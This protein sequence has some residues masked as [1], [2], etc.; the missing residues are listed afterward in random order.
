MMKLLTSKWLSPPIGAVVYI[1]ATILLWKTPTVPHMAK[2]AVSAEEGKPSW[3]F[4]NPEAEQMMDELKLQK[5]A[6]DKREQQVA[7]A[8]KRMEAERAE[9]AKVTNS[10]AGMQKDFDKVVLRVQEEEITNLKRL[11]KVY[12]AMTPDTAAMIFADL[13]DAAIVK[14]MIFMK[15]SETAQVLESFAKKGDAEAKRAAAI[16]ERLRLSTSHQSPK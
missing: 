3:E 16:S 6:L 12:A 11:A 7:E 14:I 5:R 13:D 2:N 9:M 10:V 8:E 1:V 15:D 4:T